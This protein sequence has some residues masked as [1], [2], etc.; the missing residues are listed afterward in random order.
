MNRWR[1]HSR[2]LLTT[3]LMLGGLT[4]AMGQSLACESLMHAAAPC[5]PAFAAGGM[6]ATPGSHQPSEPACCQLRVPV[7]DC[8]LANAV[9]PGASQ[10]AALAVPTSVLADTH[11][12]EL[13]VTQL[14]P[15]ALPPPTSSAGLS[16]PLYLRTAR[17]RL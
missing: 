12:P 2:K 13:R 7:P 14:A 17:L 11:M 8:T 5:A 15:A 1:L 10:V 3:L 4:M 16:A 9:V 6:H